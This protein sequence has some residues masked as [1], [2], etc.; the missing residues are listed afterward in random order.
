M[1]ILGITARSIKQT[2]S[3]QPRLRAKMTFNKP[4]FI[5]TCY[6]L[7]DNEVITGKSQYQ[8][9]SLRFPCND[10]IFG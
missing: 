4:I 5:I 9:R 3:L 6:L 2:H 10:L 7:T 1:L 8:G